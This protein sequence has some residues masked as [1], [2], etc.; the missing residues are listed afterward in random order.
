MDRG[1]IMIYLDELK[2][3]NYHY[4][5]I[6]HIPYLY[7][8]FSHPSGAQYRRSL[9]E[10]ARTHHILVLQLQPLT[11]HW[12][13]GLIA[14]GEVMVLPECML[15][16]HIFIITANG[17]FLS[18]YHWRLYLHHLNLDHSLIAYVIIFIDLYP[19]RVMV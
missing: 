11:H 3:N 15:A 13:A 12:N 8:H 9:H 5:I 14:H 1:E 2:N 4:N 16:E 6:S 18:T 19:Q 10:M 17:F 7:T